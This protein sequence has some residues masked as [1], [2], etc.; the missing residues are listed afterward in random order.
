MWGWGDGSS[1]RR[2]EGIEGHG[3]WGSNLND[4]RGEAC[5]TNLIKAVFFVRDGG[6]KRLHWAPIYIHPICHDHGSS[7]SSSIPSPRYCCTINTEAVV[8]K[9]DL[10][11]LYPSEGI[12]SI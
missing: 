5:G 12:Q 11:F 3:T 9:S 7:P 4:A 6:I 2:Y 1:A 8:A 10:D